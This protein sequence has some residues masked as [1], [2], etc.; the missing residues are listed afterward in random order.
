[1]H[2]SS[3][4]QQPTDDLVTALL[5]ASRVLVGVSARSLSDVEGAVS[6]TQFRMLVVLERS[7]GTNLAGLAKSLGVN[8][9]TALRMVDR[10]VTAGCVER[11]DNPGNRRE[12]VLTLSAHGRG[13]VADVTDRRRAEIAKIVSAMSTRE[14]AGLV[15]AL[16][17]FA[18]AADEPDPATSGGLAAL[19]W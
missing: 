15:A 2:D 9:S 16:Q 13:I 11:H 1:M 8:A 14:R 18:D 5:T 6:L 10:L 4:Q 17:A 7:P 3:D 19:G 12:V